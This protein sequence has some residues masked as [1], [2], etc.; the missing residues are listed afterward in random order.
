MD[1]VNLTLSHAVRRPAIAL[2]AGLVLATAA[3]G[4]VVIN[5]IHYHPTTGSDLEF[6]ELYNTE[7]VGLSLAGYRFTE[8]L[9][10]TFPPDAAIP[11]MGYVVLA[12][13]PSLLA[14]SFGLGGEAER[15][16]GP[17]DSNL[18][19]GGE[20]LVLADP[21][22]TTADA[23]AYNDKLPWDSG[24]DGL[25][26]SLERVCASTDAAMPWNWR[27]DSAGGPTPLRL[28]HHAECPAPAPP[29]PAVVIN[30]IHYHP[31]T[32]ADAKQEFVEIYNTTSSPIDLT[33]YEFA[34]GI[35]FKF[36]EGVTLPPQGYLVVCRNLAA[37]RDALALGSNAVGDFEG[38]LD[39]GGERITL[40][41][42]RGE[43]VDS[44]RYGDQGDWPV[45]PDGLG[46]SLEKIA[47]GAPGDDP[48]S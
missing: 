35:H 12:R 4:G 30:E 45:A 26:G 34:Q 10:Y 15:I 47:P 13:N 32:D 3:R 39:N 31:Q 33:G 18:D 8:G 11:G 37:A 43:I 29:P 23:I 1:R 36:P 38:Q 2:A 25:G 40:F 44:M 21:T 20:E 48:A 24:A 16:F 7:L 22:G 42:P 46:R 27:A 41:D 17:Y 9:R 6:V 5:E 19:N 28:N 14:E